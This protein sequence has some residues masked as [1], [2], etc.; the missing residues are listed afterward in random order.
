[1]KNVCTYNSA[2]KAK[3]YCDVNV[4]ADATETGFTTVPKRDT[5][6]LNPDAAYFHYCDNETVHGQLI[7]HLLRKRMQYS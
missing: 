6:K 4:V 5:W 7:L 2:K 3:K 1:M